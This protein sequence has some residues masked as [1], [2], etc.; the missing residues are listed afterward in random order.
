MGND[1]V[2]AGGA[3]FVALASIV[4]GAFMTGKIVAGKTFDRLVDQVDRIT[5]ALEKRNDIDEALLRDWGPSRVR[6]T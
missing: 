2:V 5:T 4:I 6:K 3:T 1:A